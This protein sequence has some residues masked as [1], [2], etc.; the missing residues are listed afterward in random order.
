VIETRLATPH[1]YDEA[2]RVTA[3]AYAEFVGPGEHAWAEYV[4]EI[5]DVRSRADVAEVIVALDEGRI[6]GSATLELGDRIDA[7]D[8]PL[9]PD[10]AHIRMLGVDPEARGRGVARALMD[11]CFATARE[12]G[13]SRMTLYTTLRMHAAQTMYASMG[14]TRLEDRVFPVGFVLLSYERPIGTWPT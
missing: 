5:A 6:V 10:E 3:L 4:D 13:R 14:F 9:G 7:D 11:A 12:A 1:E 2:G 8:P